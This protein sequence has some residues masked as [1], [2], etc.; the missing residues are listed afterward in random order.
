MTRLASIARQLYWL[1]PLLLPAAMTAWF[2]DS[3]GVNLP[4]NDSWNLAPTFIAWHQ[5]GIQWQEV[6]QFHTEHRIALP[7]LLFYALAEAV[8]WNARA[9]MWLGWGFALVATMLLAR[10]IFRSR[11]EWPVKAAVV[12]G[13]ASMIF[14]WSQWQNWL[15]G[16]QMPWFLMMALLVGGA[17]VATGGGRHGI[18][19]MMALAVLCA[20]ATFTLANGILFW[21]I[22]GAAAVW[23]A[24][25]QGRRHG[26]VTLIGMT[27]L[28]TCAIAFFLHGYQPA[29]SQIGIGAIAKAP[30]A[31]AP[32][33]LVISLHFILP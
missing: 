11:L 6:F 19:R 31:L 30:S 32:I 8:G 33:V 4:V 2:I 3:Y 1:W 21:P 23:A 12:L 24:W 13:M 18:G 15:W 9:E 26:W 22:L 7:R 14:G 25:Q 20:A 17:V 16:F 28:G 10:P 5:R 27:L 29:P